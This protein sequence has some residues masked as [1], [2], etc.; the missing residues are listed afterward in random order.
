MI[1]NEK[2]YPNVCSSLKSLRCPTR[3]TLGSMVSHFQKLFDVTSLSGVYPRMNEVYTRLGELT[4]AMRNLRDILDLGKAH[5]VKEELNRCMPL[6]VLF[7]IR[8]QSLS[9]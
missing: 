6:K 8:Q 1:L 4:N 9:C 3:Y 2:R 5:S 7:C